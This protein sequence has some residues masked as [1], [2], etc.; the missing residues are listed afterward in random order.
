MHGVVE[1][2]GKIDGLMDRVGLA[3]R[4][5]HAIFLARLQ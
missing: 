3:R 5:Q 2:Y 4:A 1:S